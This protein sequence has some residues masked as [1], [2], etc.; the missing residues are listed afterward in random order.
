MSF[1][2]RSYRPRFACKN[3]SCRKQQYFFQYF[4][5]FSHTNTIKFH[6]K[7]FQFF[8]L[9]LL[10]FSY[11]LRNFTFGGDV[12]ILVRQLWRRWYLLCIWR[13]NEVKQCMWPPNKWAYGHWVC[14][15]SLAFSRLYLRIFIGNRSFCGHWMV[16]WFSDNFSVLFWGYNDASIFV[17]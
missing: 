15:F 6:K 14:C 13:R 11:C 12:S 1:T 17:I 2:L 4:L 8:P 10:V 9:F 5:L 3:T 16:K 7:I